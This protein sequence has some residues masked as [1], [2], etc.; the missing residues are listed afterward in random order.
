MCIGGVDALFN[1]T[2]LKVKVLRVRSTLNTNFR[3]EGACGKILPTD[4]PAV[5]LKKVHRRNRPQQRT[6]SLGAEQQ[7][8]MQEWARS[9]CVQARFSMLFVPRAWDADKHSYKM[10]RIRVDTPLEV[11]DT[12]DHPVL[13][14]LKVFYAMAQKALVFPIDYELY[15]QPDGRV[16]MVDFDK[17]ASWHDGEIVFPW[18]ATVK[19]SAIREQIPFLFA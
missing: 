1:F 9:L 17:F 15:V 4:N 8:R 14:E 2:N 12:K 11:L 6:C 19:D 7:A 18:G 10:D 13:S 5:V 16:A 3:M